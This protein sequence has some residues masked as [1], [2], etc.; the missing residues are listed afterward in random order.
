MRYVWLFIAALALG[1]AACNGSSAPEVDSPP[2]KEGTSEA[3][4]LRAWRREGFVCEE[5]VSEIG[6]GAVATYVRI[7]PT[8]AS[9]GDWYVGCH[10]TITG[11]TLL[12]SPQIYCHRVSADALVV[13]NI[14]DDDKPCESLPGWPQE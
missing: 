9:N 12:P 13:T 3:Q 2:T 8:L 7:G 1:I 14:A 10:V 11:D 4:V 6:N 5:R